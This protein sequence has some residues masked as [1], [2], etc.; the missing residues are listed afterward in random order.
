MVS[1]AELEEQV[2]G[3]PFSFFPF[4]GWQ[5]TE[6]AFLPFTSFLFCFSRFLLRFLEHFPHTGGA[7]G[8]GRGEQAGAAL[9]GCSTGSARRALPLAVAGRG[10]GRCMCVAVG[11]SGQAR[12]NAPEWWCGLARGGRLASQPHHVAGSPPQPFALSPCLLFSARKSRASSR[13]QDRCRLPPQLPCRA[14]RSRR[15]VHAVAKSAVLCVLR[16]AAL[17]QLAAKEEE[18]LVA[19]FKANLEYN[20]GKVPGQYRGNTSAVPVQYH[21]GTLGQMV[22]HYLGSEQPCA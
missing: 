9:L 19:D 10:R 16:C 22:L 17:P 13:L 6:A 21:W 1:N 5:A 18:Q 7:L 4:M 11:W 2:R 12:A 3:V 20:M 8:M 15:A 14:G